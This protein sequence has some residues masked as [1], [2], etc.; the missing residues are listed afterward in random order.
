[1]EYRA[2]E[3]PNRNKAEHIRDSFALENAAQVMPKE[4]TKANKDDY[5]S[6]LH[7]DSPCIL[8]Q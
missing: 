6:R 7:Y 3:S 8:S 4:D 1:V 2:Q 5:D